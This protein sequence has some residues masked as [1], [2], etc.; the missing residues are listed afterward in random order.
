MYCVTLII[1]L[2][3]LVLIIIITIIIT[4]PW[5]VT[6]DVVDLWQERLC[7]YSQ[8]KKMRMVVL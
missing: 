3:L 7:R 8:F 6:T 1:L 5:V 2:L 4:L